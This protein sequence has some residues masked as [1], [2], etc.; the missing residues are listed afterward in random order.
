M[1]TTTQNTN[2]YPIL[3]IVNEIFQSFAVYKLD[4]KRNEWKRFAL[5][6]TLEQFL[7]ITTPK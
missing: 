1:G 5:I 4:L 2:Y 3:T 7:P 6:V